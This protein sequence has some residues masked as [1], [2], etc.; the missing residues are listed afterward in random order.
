[1]NYFRYVY[2]ENQRQ[3]YINVPHKCRKKKT[4]INLPWQVENKI[5]KSKVNMFTKQKK[6]HRRNLKN[7]KEEVSKVL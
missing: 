7:K 1:V 2:C 4:K 3:K 5:S 6:R